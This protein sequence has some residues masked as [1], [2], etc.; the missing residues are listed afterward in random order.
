MKGIQRIGSQQG[1]Q[2]EE[3][4]SVGVLDDSPL[5]PPQHVCWLN[6]DVPVL[7]EGLTEHNPSYRGHSERWGHEE[8]ELRSHSSCEKFPMK[9]HTGTTNEKYERNTQKG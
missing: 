8:W 3:W 4:Q 5:A 7:R 9:M 2:D 1:R 6:A